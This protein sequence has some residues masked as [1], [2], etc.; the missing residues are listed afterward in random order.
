M[1]F[2]IKYLYLLKYFLARWLHGSDCNVDLE[3]ARIHQ[4]LLEG[5]NDLN[6]VPNKDKLLES[7]TD[8]ENGTLCCTPWGLAIDF[9]NSLR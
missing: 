8:C 5:Q 7:D 4:A 2:V 9:Y 6:T 3:L 1:S